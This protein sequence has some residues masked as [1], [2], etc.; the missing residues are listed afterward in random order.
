MR[1]A[2]YIVVG[3]VTA[4]CAGPPPESPSSRDLA[5]EAETT[6]QRIA[7][8]ID[9][10]PSIRPGGYEVDDGFALIQAFRSAELDVRGVSL[11]FGNAPL[12]LEIPIGQEIV[13]RFGPTGLGVYAGAAGPEE[14]G[15]A[16]DAS[17]ALAEALRREPLT[18]LVLGTGTNIGTVLMRHPDLADRMV[19]LI[20]VAG[21]RPGQRFVT[22]EM[23][24]SPF[25]DC[26]FDKDPESF[27]VMLDAGVSLTLT[28]W[29]ISSHVWLRG[30]DLD[31]LEQGPAAARWLVPPARYWLGVWTSRFGVEGFNPFDTLAVGYLTSPGLITCDMLSAEIQSLPDDQAAMTGRAEVPDKPYLLA[32]RDLDADDHVRYCHTPADSFVGDLMQRLLSE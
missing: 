26:N 8:W 7:V 25:C 11:V 6:S 5:V 4:A 15:E 13:R 31:R 3:T 22:G 32:S 21:R 1:F 27:Q 23:T 17:A 30:E 20:A 24:N 29:E 16:T 9:T 18:I 19:E 2:W 14:L 12:D 28:P 10:D